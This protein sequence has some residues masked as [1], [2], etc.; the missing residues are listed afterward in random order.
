LALLGGEAGLVEALMNHGAD[1]ALPKHLSVSARL[2]GNGHL[3]PLLRRR[4]TR[5]AR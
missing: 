4:V 1:P 3:L 5:R 2:S